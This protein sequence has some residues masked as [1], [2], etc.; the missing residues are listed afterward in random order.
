MYKMKIKFKTYHLL[1]LL[2]VPFSVLSQPNLPDD[3]IVFDDSSVPRIDI[4]IHPDTLD[5]IYQNVESYIEWRATFIFSSYAITDTL[6]EVGFRLRGNTSRYSAKKSFKV[7]FNTYE[8]GRKW[9]GLEKLNLNGEHNDPSIMR[10]KLSWDIVRE[11]GLPGSRCNHVLLYINGNFHGVYINVEQIDEEFVGSRFGNNDGNLFKCLYPADL[12]YKGANPELYKQVYG[13][14]RA[15]D[16]KTNKAADDYT[17]LADFIDLLNNTSSSNFY[18]QITNSFNVFDYLKAAAIDV[19]TANWDGYIYNKNNFYLYHNT[20]TNKFEF[21]HYD[22]DNTYGIDW[23]GKE[24]SSRDIYDWQ[25]HGSEVRPLYTEMMENQELRDLYTA[26][27]R[28]L[29]DDVFDPEH[30]FPRL[31]E[32]RDM[33]APYVA[34]DPYYPLDYGYDIDDFYNSFEQA[35]GGH[36]E[37]GIKQYI[38]ERRVAANAQLEDNATIPI[39]NYISYNAPQ[40]DEEIWISAL[41]QAQFPLQT[42]QI[43]YQINEGS[44]QYA[45]MYDDGDHEDG[46]AGDGIYGAMIQ[47]V[48]MYNTISW[49]INA[50]DDFGSTNTLPCDPV[51]FEFEPSTNPALF[52]NEFMADNDSIIMDEA[53]E[54]DDW[55]EIYNGENFP[56]WLGDKYLTD[57]LENPDKW[58]FPDITIQPGEFILVWADEDQNQGPLHTNFKLSKSG[59]EIGLFDSETTA[60]FPLDTIV[61][62]EQSLNVPYGRFMDG[63][64]PWMFL[65]TPTPGSSNE[66]NSITEKD[67]ENFN[68]FPNPANGNWLFLNQKVDGSILNAQGQIIKT[69]EQTQ[70]INVSELNAGI[71]I[72]RTAAGDSKKL[73][74]Q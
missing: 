5:W 58:M 65:N 39:I 15:Y 68:I 6:E 4:L 8:P 18:C 63:S 49:Q 10:S 33:I 72:I 38:N 13:E 50:T 11:M 3:G 23:F 46:D 22:L 27:M 24:W 36:A 47:G 32:L 44:N 2:L 60:F 41:I 53:G 21:I 62:G 9:Y 71:Y 14:R 64:T 7:S 19:F 17:D 66:T 34:D 16:L 35:I 45:N 56:V 37:K 51:V 54:Y 69:F 1:L 74:I 25:Q 20:E 26:Y 55:I 12:K 48:G 28:Q 57:N 42:T 52:I 31:D 70:Q 40:P 29:V 59:E 61:Y 30:I 67:F 73:I 43:V